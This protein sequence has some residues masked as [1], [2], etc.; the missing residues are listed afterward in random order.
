MWIHFHQLHRQINDQGGYFSKFSS[1]KKK[2]PSGISSK[3]Q[4]NC[5][6]IKICCNK[7]HTNSEF[8][9]LITN[10]QRYCAA[11]EFWDLLQNWRDI[12]RD[13][14]RVGGEV[15]RAGLNATTPYKGP[16]SA[17]VGHHALQSQVKGKEKE[18]HSPCV[19]KG[20]RKWN[21]GKGVIQFPL[22]LKR[23]ELNMIPDLFHYYSIQLSPFTTPM[24]L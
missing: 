8:L 20:M 2:L 22:V 10:I 21:G 19:Q 13:R 7:F 14:D 16:G 3:F 23:R 6:M 18:C 9:G 1:K 17:R 4:L 5:A 24:E 12:L 15:L 11:S